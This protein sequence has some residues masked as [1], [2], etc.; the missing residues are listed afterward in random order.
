MKILFSVYIVFSALVVQA[1]MDS[2][3]R[4]QLEKY[5]DKGVTKAP[6]IK[7][8]PSAVVKEHRA[9]LKLTLIIDSVIVYDKTIKPALNLTIPIGF[10]SDYIPVNDSLYI[11]IFIA[12]NQEYDYKFYT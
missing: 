2:A 5:S 10:E 3:L 7:P 4:A 6:I 11:K 8:S 12:R 1:Q 9:K